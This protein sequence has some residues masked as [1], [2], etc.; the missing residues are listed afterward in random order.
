MKRIMAFTAAAVFAALS[1]SAFAGGWTL[2][3]DDSKIAFGSVKKDLI[4]EAHHFKSISGS[5]TEDGT[6]SIE[7]DVTS[8]ETWIDIRN[9]RMLA[10][11]FDAVN[12]PK[13][14]IST[15]I[16]MAEV[17]SMSPGQSKVISADAILTLLSNEIEVD[18]E[19]FVMAISDD[20]VLVTTDEMLLIAT[21]DLGINPGVDELMEL[22]D[23]PSITRVTP[24]T[25]RL[26]FVKS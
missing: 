14:K 21:E 23:L 24:V 5:V 18:A 4:G 20:R 10:H 19:L 25:L 2:V 17:S 15:K 13:A 12:F 7:I 11:V 1:S 6:A 3:G 16:D 9:E 8:V 22:A 26:I